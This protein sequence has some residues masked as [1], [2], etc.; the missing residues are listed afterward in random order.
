[1]KLRG[2]QPDRRIVPSVGHRA[3]TPLRTYFGSTVAVCSLRDKLECCC[4]KLPPLAHSTRVDLPKPA[5]ADLFKLLLPSR[6]ARSNDYIRRMKTVAMY[7]R[8]GV[9]HV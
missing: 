4:A 1:M 9:G 3:A 5:A 7:S 2:N 6:P 8:V